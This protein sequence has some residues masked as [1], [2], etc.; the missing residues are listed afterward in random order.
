MEC[1]IHC[2]RLVTHFYLPMFYDLYIYIFV[3]S[4]TVRLILFS[5]YNILNAASLSLSRKHV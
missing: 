5:I 2:K 3:L 1:V 4:P